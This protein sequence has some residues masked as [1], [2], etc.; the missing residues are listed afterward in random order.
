MSYSSGPW[1]VATSL[2]PTVCFSIKSDGALIA[3]IVKT[4]SPMRPKESIGNPNWFIDNDLDNVTTLANANLISSAP[5]LLKALEL[6]LGALMMAYPKYKHDRVRQSEAIILARA[7]I[8][9]AKGG[10]M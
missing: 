8:A 7:V 6:S 4:G 5:D 1:E 2:D 3:Q 9:K 10:E